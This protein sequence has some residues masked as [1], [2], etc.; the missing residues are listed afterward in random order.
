MFVPQMVE[1]NFSEEDFEEGDDD[2]DIRDGP[3]PGMEELDLDSIS[4][5]DL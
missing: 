3:G 1:F 4:W 2:D 5:M